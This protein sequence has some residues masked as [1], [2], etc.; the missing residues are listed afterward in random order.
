MPG[1][2]DATS[3]DKLIA[4]ALTRTGDAERRTALPSSGD[5]RTAMGD[6]FDIPT[7]AFS[8]AERELLWR[9]AVSQHEAR[10]S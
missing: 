5:W 6:V 2:R 8:R 3:A 7:N 10:A 1:G 9:T 4:L